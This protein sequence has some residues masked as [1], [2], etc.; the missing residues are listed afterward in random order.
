MQPESVAAEAAQPVASG[1]TEQPI[2][3]AA[4]SG[5]LGTKSAAA[6]VS[7]GRPP[8]DADGT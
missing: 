4:R 2:P 7:G 5:V 6:R 8:Y 3:E 1:P